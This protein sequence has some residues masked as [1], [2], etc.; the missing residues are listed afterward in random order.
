MVVNPRP[1][2][3]A[4]MARRTDTSQARTLIIAE[5]SAD[6]RGIPRPPAMAGGPRG[7]LFCCS[8][9]GAWHPG[10]RLSRVSDS[11][12]WPLRP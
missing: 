10:P 11:S 12:A 2:R 4:A 6:D 5:I 3:E 8:K 9:G 7:R 1:D